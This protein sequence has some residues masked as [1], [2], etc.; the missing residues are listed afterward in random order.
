VVPTE[1]PLLLSKESLKRAGA[2]LDLPNDEAIL[3]GEKL[4]LELTSSGHYCVSIMGNQNKDEV[5]DVLYSKTTFQGMNDAEKRKKLLKL[6]DQFGHASA[7]KLIQLLKSADIKDER[8]FINLQEVVDGCDTCQ[9]FKKS[10]A[11]PVV[12]LPRASD[13]NETVAVDLHQLGSNIWFLHIIDEFSRLSNACIVYNKEPETFIEMFIKHW[14]SVYG[15]PK[16]LV[17]D[18][19]GEFNNQ[20]VRDMCENFGIEVI[21]TPTYSPWSNGTCERHNLILT[22]ILVKLR[23]SHAYDWEISLCWAVAAKNTL[24]NVN[25]FSPYQI[26]FGRNPNLPNSAFSDKLPALGG[27]TTS[28]R[29]H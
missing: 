11:R 17:S 25:G 21:T 13:F 16:R 14:V 19:G 8:L 23:E 15:A 29:E 24:N 10:P 1:L 22:E 3:F 5:E 12:G 6:H 18:N 26:V 9:M 28:K 20:L 4:K 27:Q 2:E 7:M